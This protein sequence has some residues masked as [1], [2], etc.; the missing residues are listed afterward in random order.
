MN[1]DQV[2]FGL[3]ILLVVG[4]I[5]YFLPSIIAF[6]RDHHYRWIIFAINLVAGVSG[7]GY[8]AAFVWSVWPRQTAALDLVA[9]D[10]TTNSAE[11]SQKVY[12]RWGQNA[13]AFREGAGFQTGASAAPPTEHM[14]NGIS[15]SI[16]ALQELVRLK[17]DGVISAVEF[18]E[19]KKRLLDI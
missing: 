2:S 15:E 18:S 10:L 7:V 11:A 4:T 9:S 8:L 3:F 12:G 14:G 1:D 19:M 17:N 6:S 13:R 16:G 5:L